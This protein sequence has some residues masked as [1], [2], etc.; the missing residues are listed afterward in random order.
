MYSL[1]ICYQGGS[2]R[3]KTFYHSSFCVLAS[4]QVHLFIKS[5]IIMLLYAPGHGT[6]YTPG[7]F[8]W[9]AV[10][11]CAGVAARKFRSP[12]S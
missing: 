12:K 11:L 10:H 6:R 2:F 8:H 5:E 3:D 1:T 9:R 4:V 7:R